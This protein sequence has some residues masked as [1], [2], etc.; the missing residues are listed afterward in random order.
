MGHGS[1]TERP[2]SAGQMLA[3]DAA[4]PAGQKLAGA[5]LAERTARLRRTFRRTLAVL[6]L[7]FLSVSA[8][9]YAWYIYNATRHVTDVQMAAGTGVTFLISDSYDGD[10]K[11][12]AG[13]SFEGLLNPVS[14][15][16]I[17]NGFQRVA[18]YSGGG[19]SASVL[20][21]VFEAAGRTDYYQTSLYLTTNSV[22]TDVYLAGIGYDDTDAE[23]PISTALR[24]GLVVH[25]AGEN[26]AV[27]GQY[28][29]ELTADHNPQARYNTEKGSA[30]D[31]LDST[32]TDGS[33]VAFAP[34][35]SAN[36]CLYDEATGKPTL[37]DASSVLCRL[38]AAAEGAAHGTPVQVDVYVWLEGCDEDCT[39]NLASTSLDSLAL[40][41]V[42]V[43]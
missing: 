39:N 2:E 17:L 29:F 20:A 4:D 9:T 26:A 5:E 14:T 34:L 18:G 1:T 19:S 36:Y 10:Y 33:T 30:G 16:N 32:K 6:V 28:V 35:T 42:G 31:V 7:A 21:S 41:F 12:S 8:F 37:Q 23:N 15:D 27:S 24:V 22:A 25:E 38:P 3:A 13:L 11:T 40:R 43:R